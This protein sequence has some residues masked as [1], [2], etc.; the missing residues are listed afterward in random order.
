MR[1]GRA[2]ARRVEAPPRALFDV[3]VLIAMAW[4]NHVHHAAVLDWLGRPGTIAFATCPVTQSGFI[5]VSSNARAIPGARAPR[6]AQALLRRITELPGHAFWHDDVDLAGDAGVAW[7]RVGGHAQVT[8]AHL[9]AIALRRGGRLATL[10]RGIGDL[11]P[12]GA[13]SD[14]VVVIPG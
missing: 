9:L 4:P 12:A 10:D 1:A 14:A 5:R 11:V 13:R 2:G 8:D 7:D 6:E 3:N